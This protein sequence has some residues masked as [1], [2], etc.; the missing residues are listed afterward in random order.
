MQIL[1]RL[2]H[3]LSKAKDVTNSLISQLRQE[4]AKQENLEKLIKRKKD[5]NDQVDQSKSKTNSN[6][7]KN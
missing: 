1:L 7:E 3:E 4:K 2:K 5:Q 6:V